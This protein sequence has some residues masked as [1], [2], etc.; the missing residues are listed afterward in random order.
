MKIHIVL[1]TRP[2][3]IKLAPIIKELE[4]RKINFQIIHTGQHYSENMDQ[5]FWN[6]FELP[7]PSYHLSVKQPTHGAQVADMLFKLE[8]IFIKEKPDW[9]IV[10]GDTNSTLSGALAACK[11][12]SIKVAH[13]EAGL[14]SFDTTMPEEINRILVDKMSHLLFPPTELAKQYLLKDGI[15]ENKVIVCGNTIKDIL[16]QKLPEALKNETILNEL[17]L[18]NK[19]YVLVTIHRQENTDSEIRL[20]SILNSLFNQAKNNSLEVVFPIHPRTENRLKSF[21]FKFPDFVKILPPMGY[22]DFLCIQQKAMLVATDSGGLQEESCILGVPCITLRENTERPE[23]IEV[24][25]NILCGIES[26]NIEEA[27]TKAISNR[28]TWNQPYGD[29][30]CSEKIIDAILGYNLKI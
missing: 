13:V 27:F 4:K 28:N 21:G 25:S 7:L 26:K 14:R 23:T 6:L 15:N 12:Q 16:D 8:E 3:I 9:V 22:L 30:K 5:I 18:N 2:E 29:G 20:I 10:Q 1:G 11:L 19:K 24:G 17:N